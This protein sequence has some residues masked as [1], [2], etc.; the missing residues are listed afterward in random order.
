MKKLLGKVVSG[1]GMGCFVFVGLLFIG[2][3]AAG[4][5]DRFIGGL[6]GR[7]LLRYAVC[8]NLISLGY[9]VPSLIYERESLSLGIRALLH[10]GTGTLVFFLVSGFA[11]WFGQGAAAAVCYILLG[12]GIAGAIWAVYLAAFW[13]Q[14]RKMNQKIREKNQN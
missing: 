4:G 12:L 3:A 8:T 1:V 6:T 9:M 2:S 11:G 13:L 10:M 5:A 7:E 14:A